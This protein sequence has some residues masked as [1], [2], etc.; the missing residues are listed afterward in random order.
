MVKNGFRE[1]ERARKMAVLMWRLLSIFSSLVRFDS[2][3]D[4]GA[5][6]MHP[7]SNAKLSNESA[8]ACTRFFMYTFIHAAHDFK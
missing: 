4:D 7:F 6:A 1:R 3:S 5:D 8:N 2:P